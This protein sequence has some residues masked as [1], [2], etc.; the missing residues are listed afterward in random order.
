MNTE[1]INIDVKKKD[2]N[3]RHFLLL[4]F[5]CTLKE[6]VVVVGGGFGQKKIHKYI[7]IHLSDLDMYVRQEKTG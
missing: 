2:Q 5:F 1:M 6:F 4:T 3:Q 7:K